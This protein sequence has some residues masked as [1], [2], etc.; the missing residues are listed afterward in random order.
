M[1]L[2][3]GL[4]ALRG[5]DEVSCGLC[6]GWVALLLLMVPQGVCVFWRPLPWLR[7][8]IDVIHARGL[9]GRARMSTNIIP[10]CCIGRCWILSHASRLRSSKDFVIGLFW[11][12][13]RDVEL[14]SSRNWRL[15]CRYGFLFCTN[16]LILMHLPFE[17]SHRWMLVRAR[18]KFHCPGPLRCGKSPNLWRWETRMCSKWSMDCAIA[19]WRWKSLVIG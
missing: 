4:Y 7:R 16:V 2:A 13:T 10:D 9:F 14:V 6:D 1:V 8:D 11:T 3:I 5:D 15:H 17:E 18:A 19:L 12:M